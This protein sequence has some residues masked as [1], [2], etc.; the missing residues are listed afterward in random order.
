MNFNLKIKFERFEHEPRTY[1]LGE[2]GDDHNDGLMYKTRKE[3]LKH[4]EGFL[5]KGD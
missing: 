1:Y 5:M 2:G 3:T 4:L